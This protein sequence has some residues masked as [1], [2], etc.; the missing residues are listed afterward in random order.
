MKKIINTKYIIFLIILIAI[1]S[2]TDNKEETTKNIES[3]NDVELI[4]DINNEVDSLNTED[5]SSNNEIIKLDAKYNN[6]RGEVDMTI[7]YSLDNE[8]KIKTIEIDATTYNLKDFNKKAQSLIWKTIEEAKNTEL[9]VGWASLTNDAFK[10]A[11][12]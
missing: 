3:N 11:L 6:A 9:N 7:N 2:C 10:N 4:S 12:K 5:I 8:S 1:S